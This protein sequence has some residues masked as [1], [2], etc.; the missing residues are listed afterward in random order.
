MTRSCTPAARQSPDRPTLCARA[1]AE[2]PGTGLRRWRCARSAVQ[3]DRT[4]ARRSVAHAHGSSRGV[5]RP[6]R[7]AVARGAFLVANVPPWVGRPS[8]ALPAL[9]QRDVAV[10]CVEH[11]EL[12]ELLGLD[13][14]ITS[15]T[16]PTAAVARPPAAIACVSDPGHSRGHPHSA[17]GIPDSLHAYT[18]RDRRAERYPAGWAPSGSM[19]P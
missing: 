4:G 13:P 12:E 8:T 16:A 6:V 1:L 14:V 17:G 19:T 15:L 2:R 11:R 7:I 5:C 3:S 9:G 18:G 10:L